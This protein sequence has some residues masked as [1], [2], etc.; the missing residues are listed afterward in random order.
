[1]SATGRGGPY[2][3][4]ADYYTPP[5][6]PGP[7]LRALKPMLEEAEGRPVQ[8]LRFLEGHVG[9]GA[10]LRGLYGEGWTD[11]SNA[12]VWDLDPAAEG[13][14][15][16]GDHDRRLAE[17]TGELIET[18]FLATEPDIQP[19]V[20]IGNPPYG[21]PIPCDKCGGDP[22]PVASCGR[23]RGKG[24]TGL[25]PAAE[26]HVV[27]G[28]ELARHVVYLLRLGFLGT[29]ERGRLYERDCL[30]HVFTLIPRVQFKQV[31]SSCGGTGASRLW[32]VCA[33]C[34]GSGRRKGAS[35]S[36]SSEYAVF[37]FDRDW[38]RPYWTGSRLVW[39]APK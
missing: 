29:R 10:W 24:T 35:G 21:I 3:S 4:L 22:D 13:L 12:E 32:A 33:P 16:P 37:W 28:L 38:N 5:D 27:R 25:V 30:R 34:H 18:G 2:R 11:G 17:D 23:C 14:L 39:R 8:E 7:V 9:A 31:C 36:D 19:D 15:I 6:L 1:M 20:N 26:R